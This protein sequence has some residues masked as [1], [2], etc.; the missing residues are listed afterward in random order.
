MLFSRCAASFRSSIPLTTT[1]I[2]DFD[3][4]NLQNLIVVFQ[5][6]GSE[7]KPLIFQRCVSGL[8]S[9]QWVLE[10]SKGTFHLHIHRVYKIWQTGEWIFARRYFHCVEVGEWMSLGF[11]S[12]RINSRNAGNVVWGRPKWQNQTRRSVV[13]DISVAEVNTIDGSRSAYA[14][15]HCFTALI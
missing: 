11:I 15:T 5:L 7:F 12:C 13:D 4:W 3:L 1:V 10:C 9:P 2:F 6:F 8:E 14:P